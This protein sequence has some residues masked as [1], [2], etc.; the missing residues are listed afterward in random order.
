MLDNGKILRVR[1][2]LDHPLLMVLWVLANPDTFRSVAL[3]FGVLPGS[4]HD[5]YSALTVCFREMAPLYVKWPDAARRREISAAF[6][7]Y[8]GFP[9]IAGVIDGTHNNITA[10]AVQK[11]KYRNRHHTFSLNTQAVCDNRL[12]IL[13]FH[14]GEVGSLHDAR[15]FRRSPLYRTLIE[16]E[17]NE[18]L[19]AGQHIIGDKAYSLMDCVSVCNTFKCY[20]TNIIILP[21]K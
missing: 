17:N 10:P 19:D 14:V 9:G 7:G 12:L 5:H 11:E 1:K 16:N 8:S 4:L 13:D 6:E 3:H 21:M 15:V 2:R 20:S 18:M